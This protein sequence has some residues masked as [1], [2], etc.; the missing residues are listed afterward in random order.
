MANQTIVIKTQIYPSPSQAVILDNTMDAY[1]NACNRIADYIYSSKD[2]KQTS[3]HKHLYY[4]I[5]ADFKLKS[6]QACST[7][8]SVLASIRSIKSNKQAWAK[9][10]YKHTFIHIVYGS[11]YHFKTGE[12]SIMTLADR[13]QMPYEKSRIAPYL[14]DSK[15]YR[16]GTGTLI[17]RNKKYYICIPVTYEI[18]DEDFTTICNVVGVDRGMNFIVATFDSKHKSQFISGSEIKKKRYKYQKLKQQ[19]QKRHTRSS[20]RRLRKIGKREN[21]WTR[22]V[23][24]CI[25]KALVNNNPE[26][27]LFVLEDLKGIQKLA[28]HTQKKYRNESHSWPY[29]DLEE[30]LIYKAAQRQSI[31]IKVNPKYTSQCCPMCG[32]TEA[33]NRHRDKHLFVCKNCDYHS[34]DDRIGAMNLYRM[35]IEYLINKCTVPTEYISEGRGTNRLSHDA[36]SADKKLSVLNARDLKLL[37]LQDSC[38]SLVYI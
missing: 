13:I 28:K 14:N 32:H 38:K 2:V 16:L 7:V 36:T 21:R 9:P 17:K 19:L 4:G 11:D 15:K 8:K 23:N 35:G 1:T 3:I 25:S 30:K 6:Q 10:V 29:Y 24:H 18:P 22:D 5:R 37:S 26:H 20:M 34:N 31:V 33:S 27:T 12:L